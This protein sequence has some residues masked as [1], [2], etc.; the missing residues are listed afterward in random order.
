MHLFNRT[1]LGTQEARTLSYRFGINLSTRRTHTGRIPLCLQRHGIGDQFT[2][3]HLFQVTIALAYVMPRL[4]LTME[5]THDRRFRQRVFPTLL[6][7]L[8]SLQLYRTQA[9][10]IQVVGIDFINGKSRI[11]IASPTTT[12][13]EFRKDTAYA[14]MARELQS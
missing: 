3:L 8:T 4:Q 7:L 2:G 13:V 1:V 11:R 14:V 12:E 10:L 6:N 9:V 5:E